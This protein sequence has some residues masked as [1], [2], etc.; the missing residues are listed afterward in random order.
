[1][2][3]EQLPSPFADFRYSGEVE[4]GEVLAL[5]SLVMGEVRREVIRKGRRIRTTSNPRT[6]AYCVLR[7]GGND[8]LSGGTDQILSVRVR[9][10]GDYGYRAWGMGISFL[11]SELTEAGYTSNDRTLYQF[12]WDE[13]AAYGRKLSRPVIGRVKLIDAQPNGLAV[14]PATESVGNPVFSPVLQEELDVV[15]DRALEVAFAA[16]PRMRQLINHIVEGK[17]EIAA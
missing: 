12:R 6:R 14:F 8:V 5:Q 1:M 13:Q 10:L 4:L 17:L 11:E 15:A 9:K 3:A 7:N 16:N 2:G